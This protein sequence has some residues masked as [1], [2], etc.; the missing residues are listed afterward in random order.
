MFPPG[1][2]VLPAC[3]FNHR[4]VDSN[5][6]KQ[7]RDRGCPKSTEKFFTTKTTNDSIKE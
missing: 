3:G 6:F 7:V 4:L 2:S 5:L 1:I